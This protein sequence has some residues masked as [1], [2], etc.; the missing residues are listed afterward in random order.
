MGLILVA[1][2]RRHRRAYPRRAPF[3]VSTIGRRFRSASWGL[4]EPLIILGGIFSGVFT[5]S[6]SAVDADYSDTD[7][8]ALRG[9]AWDRCGAFWH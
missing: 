5:P 3:N 8:A 1:L 9:T 6:E 4:M 7:V 2:T